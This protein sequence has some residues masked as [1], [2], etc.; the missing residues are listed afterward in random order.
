M[1]PDMPNKFLQYNIHNI[2]KLNSYINSLEWL[3]ITGLGGE[4]IAVRKGFRIGFNNGAILTIKVLADFMIRTE[5]PKPLKL[6]GAV[7]QCDFLLKDF[8]DIIK[9][10]E[11]N[12]V[13]LPDDLLITLLSVSYST[14]RGIIANMT[15]GTEYP[16]YFPA[17]YKHSGI[18]GFA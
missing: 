18:Q 14:S 1:L 2:K 3:N 15:A 6:F 7:V 5:K 9:K 10:T 12:Q 16:E 11:K 4:N 8:E 13:N 17:T